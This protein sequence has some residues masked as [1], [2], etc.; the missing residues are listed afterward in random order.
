MATTTTTTT[1]SR[2]A[3]RAETAADADADADAGVATLGQRVSDILDAYFATLRY[4]RRSVKPLNL[5]VVV[6]AA[7]SGRRL[8]R[9]L[10]ARGG[11]GDGKET[12]TRIEEEEEEEE[13]EAG[14]GG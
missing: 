8:A 3:A 5:V 14:G 13:E 1:A 4:E 12:R 11:R 9:G 2:P 6:L 10:V 7:M